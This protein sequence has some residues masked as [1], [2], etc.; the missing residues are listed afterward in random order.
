MPLQIPLATFLFS[1]GRPRTYSP[2]KHPFDNASLLFLCSR[3]VSC[4]YLYLCVMEIALT[5]FRS[6][7]VAG[8]FRV[9]YA[10]I[11]LNSYDAMCKSSFAPGL[12]LKR[13]YMLTFPTRVRRRGSHF[14]G[15]GTRH[16]SCLR[17]PPGLQT[18]SKQNVPCHL[19]QP[20]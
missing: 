12:M 13:N 3:S 5:G 7:C 16:R 18:S 2:F 19:R 10:H 14:R 9:W 17:L 15:C 20:I 1:S 6:A 8:V 4:K 11:Y